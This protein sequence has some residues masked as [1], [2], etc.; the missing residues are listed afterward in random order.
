MFANP[1][2]VADASE[3]TAIA[4][5]ADRIRARLGDLQIVCSSAG[6]SFRS[7]PLDISDDDFDWHSPEVDAKERLGQRS[8]PVRRFV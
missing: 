5:A 2:E 7:E 3:C 6:V 8:R 4:A 1:S